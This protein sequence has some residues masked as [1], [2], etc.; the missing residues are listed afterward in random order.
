M[1]DS[2]YDLN[3]LRTRRALRPG[4]VAKVLARQEE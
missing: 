3:Y 1:Y 2:R 4:T